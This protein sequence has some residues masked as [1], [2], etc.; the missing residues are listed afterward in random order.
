MLSMGNACQLL[1]KVIKSCNNQGI[2]VAI[3][4][5]VSEHGQGNILVAPES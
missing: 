2:V 1:T 4:K 5:V 3:I